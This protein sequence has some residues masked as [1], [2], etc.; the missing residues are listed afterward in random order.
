MHF[1]MRTEVGSNAGKLPSLTSPLDI[2][3]H[4]TH[5]MKSSGSAAISGHLCIYMTIP[6]DLPTRRCVSVAVRVFFN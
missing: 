2:I 5:G 4:V 3:N 6:R 1:R